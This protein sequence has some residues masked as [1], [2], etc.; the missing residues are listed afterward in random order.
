MPIFEF[1]CK[2]CS[3]KFEDLILK[4][5]DLK[6]IQCPRCGAKEIEKLFSLFGFCGTGNGDS[7]S[8]SLSSCSGC[9]RTTC[10]GCK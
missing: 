10:A 1:L 2:K 4:N 8:N 6:D 7:K 3:N 9:Q 5:D